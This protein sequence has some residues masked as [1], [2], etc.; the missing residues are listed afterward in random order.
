MMLR[1]LPAAAL[2]LL[3]AASAVL[4]GSPAPAFLDEQPT[5]LI[6]VDI[7]DFYFPGGVLPLVEPEAAAA[8]AALLLADFRQHG[9]TVVHVG[10]KVREG[11]GFRAELEPRPDELAIMKSEVSCFNGNDLADLLRA[12]GVTRVLV[13]GM[14]THMCLEGAVRAAYDL[15]F[16]CLVAED[17]C[18]TRDLVRGDVTIPAALV[19]VSTL[20]TLDGAYARVLKTKHLL[21]R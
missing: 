20:A 1:S 21:G 5:A 2:V 15:G 16:E 18:A 7:Q 12:R 9:R 4:A 6:I 17:A 3:A 11:G 10:H 14:Q 19:H 8:N 13:C